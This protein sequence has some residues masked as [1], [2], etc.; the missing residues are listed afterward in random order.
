GYGQSCACGGSRGGTRPIIARG[1]VRAAMPVTATLPFL[2]RSRWGVLVRRLPC[3]RAMQERGSSRKRGG[4]GRAARR[5]GAREPRP[6]CARVAATA[7]HYRRRL[8]TWR[9]AERIVLR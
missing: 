1:A 3:A 8:A 9:R 7:D 5:R 4:Y 6:T 2:I